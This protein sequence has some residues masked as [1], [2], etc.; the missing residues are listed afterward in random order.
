MKS[1]LQA[2]P[3]KSLS[4][5]F[6]VASDQRIGDDTEHGIEALTEHIKDP[7]VR[8]KAARMVRFNTM[9]SKNIKWV[10]ITIAT[11]ILV[12]IGAEIG[13]LINMVE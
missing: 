10:T 6:T 11:G 7:K 5:C 12:G 4:L 8:R 2:L 3:A 13:G 9:V 1:L